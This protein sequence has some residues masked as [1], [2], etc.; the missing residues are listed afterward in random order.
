MLHKTKTF[1]SERYLKF[2]RQQPCLIS[3]SSPCVPHHTSKSGVSL[4]GSDYETVPLIPELHSELHAIGQ[5]TFQEKHNVDFSAC[6]TRLLSEYINKL[7]GH[8]G[9]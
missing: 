4:K 3:G 7:E 1:R 8:N 6:I 2:I 9:I 5:K